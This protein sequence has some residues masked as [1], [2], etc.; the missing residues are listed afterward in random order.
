M[1]LIIQLFD[2]Q[3]TKQT[4]TLTL[5]SQILLSRGGGREMDEHQNPSTLITKDIFLV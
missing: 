5:F 4:L 1:L 2:P 3:T